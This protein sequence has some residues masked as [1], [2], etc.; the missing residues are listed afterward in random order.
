MDSL[1]P[2]IYHG[3]P[4]DTYLALPYAS[5][6]LLGRLAI[7]PAHAL[8]GGG[9]TQATN[10][11]RACHAYVLEGESALK[12]QFA[13]GP[14]VGK[15]KKEEKAVWDKFM[16]TVGDRSVIKE[17]EYFDIISMDR[18]IHCNPTAA[19]WLEDGESE[20]TIIWDAV[21]FDGSP[22]GV[23]CKG[24]IDRLPSNYKDMIVDL[25]TT[26]NAHEK[27]FAYSIKKYGYHR[28]AAMYMHALKLLVPSLNVEKFGFIAVEKTAPFRTECY[29]LTSPCQTLMDGFSDYVGLVKKYKLCRDMD[30]FPNYVNAGAQELFVINEE[31]TT[32]Q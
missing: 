26:E 3:I 32:W 25:K 8:L 28:Q 4:F 1:E 18:A 20:I 19:D 12:E 5:N 17:S 23:R 22:I 9:D 13:V 16:E 6:S 21:D 11:G 29:T 2:G 15:K 7:T 14:G 30:F 27:S 10:L 31:V 24:R